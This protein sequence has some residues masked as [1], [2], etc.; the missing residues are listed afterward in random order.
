ML[1]EPMFA[2]KM[3]AVPYGARW[4]MEPKFDGW[5][6][7]A[8]TIGAVRLETRT[9]NQITQVPY[10][11]SAVAE[12]IPPQTIID[13]ELVDLRSG[14]RQ[15]N[16][17]QTILSTTRGGYEHG[18]S[19]EDPPLTYVI[20]DVL[21][22]AGED[23][24]QR[25]LLQ[26]KQR[27]VELLAGIAPDGVLMQ[28]P[29]HEATEEGLAALLADGFEG[30]VVKDVNSAYVCGGR[31]HGWYKIKPE[32]EIE[33]LCTGTYP[34]EPGS[35]YAPLVDGE[36][37]PWAVGGIRFQVEHDDGRIYEG[38]AAG[39][40]DQLRREL[41]EKPECF[42]GRVVELIH[43]G[44]Q[45]RGALRHPNFK[46]FRS[47]AEKPAATTASAPVSEGKP[48]ILHAGHLHQRQTPYAQLRR[49]GRRQAVALHRQ[50]ARGLGRGL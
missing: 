45:D 14:E 22:I 11:A 31:R 49:D 47:P 32:E 24:R 48:P 4:L 16:R 29:I 7:I 34:A 41:H 15:W 23:L 36:P 9:G 46:R 27:L 44:I 17:T 28:S 10:I 39:M 38:R 20:F 13:G 8:S 30:V 6:A 2:K 3:T 19:D 40:N 26:R 12:T 1:R 25:P 42:E 21:Q 33:A 5:R 35:K 37:R 50:P 18:P 43:W